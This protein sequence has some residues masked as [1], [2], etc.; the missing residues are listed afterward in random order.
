MFPSK[1][2]FH[3]SIL[4]P[5]LTSTLVALS[6]AVG[7]YGTIGY[8]LMGNINKRERFFVTTTNANITVQ[9]ETTS[10]SANPFFVI[11]GTNA[12]ATPIELKINNGEYIHIG[13]RGSA[14]GTGTLYLRSNSS[15]GTILA[16]V[17]YTV[18][19]GRP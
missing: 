1:V 9:I 19:G 18:S 7:S 8:V 15:T 17:A 11:T 14:I 13:V 4:T 10:T 5:R 6:R 3:S 2:G 12:F 16:S